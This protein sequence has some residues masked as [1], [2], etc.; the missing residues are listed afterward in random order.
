MLHNIYIKLMAAVFGDAAATSDRVQAIVKGFLGI[1]F[2]E[3]GAGCSFCNAFLTPALADKLALVI[4]A[5][6][7]TL[8]ASLTKRDIAAPGTVVADGATAPAVK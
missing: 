6:A 7:V 8:V 3:I 5:G 4:G 1:V 2:V